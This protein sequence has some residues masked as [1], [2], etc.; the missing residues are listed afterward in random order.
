MQSDRTKLSGWCEAYDA[1]AQ[2][3]EVLGTNLKTQNLFNDRREV[4]QRANDREGRSIGGAR[5]TPRGGQ[6]QRVLDRIERHAAL[7]E[8][9]REQTVP[10]APGAARAI[11]RT[12]GFQPPADIA[13]LFHE[14]SPGHR[15]ATSR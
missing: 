3:V 12:L 7:V 5:Q 11:S 9:G 14:F 4:G 6:C 10:A 1:I 8:L 2:M 15:P 13:A